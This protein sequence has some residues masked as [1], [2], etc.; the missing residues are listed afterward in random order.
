MKKLLFFSSLLFLSCGLSDLALAGPEQRKELNLEMEGWVNIYYLNNQQIQHTG[1][2]CTFGA[3]TD[4]ELTLRP[5]S[6]FNIYSKG[7][8][9]L[10]QELDSTARG[11]EKYTKEPFEV[12]TLFIGIETKKCGRVCLGKLEKGAGNFNYP[13][14]VPADIFIP[15]DRTR[16]L[17]YDTGIFW[18]FGRRG[19]Q[20]RTALINGVEELDSNSAKGLFIQIEKSSKVSDSLRGEAGVFAQVQDGRGS[21][22]IKYDDNYIGTFLALDAGRLRLDT[23]AAYHYYGYGDYRENMERAIDEHNYGTD[24]D[25]EEGYN[26][27]NPKENKEGL[28]WHISADIVNLFMENLKFSLSYSGF[29]PNLESCERRADKIKD[30]FVSTIIYNIENLDI[31][32]AVMRGKDPYFFSKRESKESCFAYALG[33]RLHF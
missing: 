3:F 30:R 23:G 1:N 27:D 17:R 6:N 20:A 19:W 24:F 22:P 26:F 15:L 4:V 33:L 8:F 16:I 31:F 9:R 11:Y 7:L 5:Y 2:E 25:L 32:A 28:S 13:D 12:R 29:I 14:F 10:Q 21:T 18:D